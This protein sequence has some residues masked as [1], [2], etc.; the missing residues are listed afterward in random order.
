MREEGK[1]GQGEE[2]TEGRRD[3]CDTGAPSVPSS[4]LPLFPSSLLAGSSP[5]V[6]LHLHPLLLQD[7]LGLRG[8]LEFDVAVAV[9]HVDA[10]AAM[11][12]EA[13]VEDDDV[14]ARVIALAGANVDV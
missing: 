8:D 2:V 6:V 10:V 11:V 14:G 13:L 9:E 4:P 7:L 12:A 1:R 3:K 5:P